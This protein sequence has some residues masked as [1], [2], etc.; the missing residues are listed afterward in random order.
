M[1]KKLLTS[2]R[3][4]IWHWRV[5]RIHFWKKKKFTTKH[6]RKF[7]RR[8]FPFHFTSTENILCLLILSDDL[9]VFLRI[10]CF[11]ATV[12]DVLVTSYNSILLPHTCKIYYVKIHHSYVYMQLIDVI[13]RIIYENLQLSMPP[14]FRFWLIVWCFVLYQHINSHIFAECVL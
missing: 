8:I 3:S 2:A 6:Y 9:S 4:H 7:Q 14:Y 11:L 1:N 10:L 5:P 13:K 12:S